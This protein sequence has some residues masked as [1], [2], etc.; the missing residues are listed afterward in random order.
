MPPLIYQQS[1][2]RL[3]HRTLFARNT[4]LKHPV[5]HVGPV[6]PHDHTTRYRHIHLSHLLIDGCQQEFSTD[7][8]G[9]M[10]AWGT[11]IRNNGISIRQCDDVVIQYCVVRN[12][13]SGGIVPQHCTNVLIEH[14]V[15]EDNFFDGIAPYHCQRVRIKHCIFRNNRAA[16]ISLD[17]GCKYVTISHCRFE[18]TRPVSWDVWSR[19]ASGVRM[20]PQWSAQSCHRGRFCS[21]VTEQQQ[22]TVKRKQRQAKKSARA[23]Y[24]N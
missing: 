17:G 18:N 8:K 10:S 23:L 13:R 5:V 22:N 1:Q 7:S 16:G 24:S 19:E 3:A 20:L 2:V 12:C 21:V 4:S 9:E 15:L 14:C 11:H 6:T